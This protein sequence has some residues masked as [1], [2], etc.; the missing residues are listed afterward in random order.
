M[1]DRTMTLEPPDLKRSENGWRMSW[2]DTVAMLAVL[3]SLFWVLLAGLYLGFSPGDPDFIADDKDVRE[4]QDFA[5]AA[6]PEPATP[7][8]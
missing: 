5:P 2:P 4:L 3:C 7:G 8:N 6:G 1:A